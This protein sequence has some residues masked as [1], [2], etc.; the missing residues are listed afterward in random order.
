MFPRIRSP[1]LA[2]RGSSLGVC[3]CVLF[4]LHSFIVFDFMGFFFFALIFY[5]YEV[6][7]FEL[8]TGLLIFWKK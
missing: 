6:G 8:K 7:G 3:R 4:G 5:I 2:F 1:T